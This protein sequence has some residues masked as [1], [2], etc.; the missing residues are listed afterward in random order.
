MMSVA[1][2]SSASSKSFKSF[3]A[4]GSALPFSDF[5]PLNF[6]P[7]SGT[8]T[9]QSGVDFTYRYTPGERN[10]NIYVFG[11]RQWNSTHVL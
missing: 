4:L 1:S 6:Y 8:T 11:A 3:V 10:H 2:P 5:Q 9:A 7:A